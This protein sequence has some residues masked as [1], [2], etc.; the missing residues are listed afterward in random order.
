[1]V[2]NNNTMKPYHGTGTLSTPE[3][4]NDVAV[5]VE[6]MCVKCGKRWE[7]ALPLYTRLKDIRCSLCGLDGYVINTGQKL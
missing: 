3:I 2:N 6:L 1:M 5:C 4:K 7:T